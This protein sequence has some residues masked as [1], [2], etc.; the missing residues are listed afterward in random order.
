MISIRSCSSLLASRFSPAKDSKSVSDSPRSR[1][2]RFR[3]RSG[4]L[5]NLCK[6]LSK[7]IWA[8]WPFILWF[9]KLVFQNNSRMK[10]GKMRIGILLPKLFRPTVRKMFY[11]LR[12]TFEIRGWRPRI[13]K[14]FEITRTICSNSERSEQFLVTECFF[15]L[16]LR[17]SDLID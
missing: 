14:N 6:A 13:C 8:H 5:L 3:S 16:F 12:K 1:L 4:G 11:W 10:R 15:N 17:F 2:V 9:H 7:S